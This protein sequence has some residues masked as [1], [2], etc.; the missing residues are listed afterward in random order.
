MKKFLL[1]TLSVLL[2]LNSSLEVYAAETTDDYSDELSE[3][4]GV[5]KLYSV[6][7]DD[8]KALLDE[9]GGN[10]SVRIVEAC[11]LLDNPYADNAT[12][13]SMDWDA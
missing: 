9:R 2:F 3:S 1:I 5:D 7:S 11:R 10:L 4:L 12:V 8:V 6:L 13:V